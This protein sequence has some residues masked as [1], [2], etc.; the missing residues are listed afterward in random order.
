MNQ[1]DVLRRIEGLQTI[2]TITYKLNIKRQSAIN[3]ISRLKKQGYVT[4][5]GGG[6]KI[7]LYKITMRK[8]RNRDIGMFDILNKYNP[9][10]Q[11]RDWYDHQVHGNYTIED[12]IVDAIQTGSF[13]AILATLRLF[14]H[15]T[16]WSRL[17]RLAKERG[18]WQKVGALYDV[19]KIYYKVRRVPAKYGPLPFKK[20][21][22]IRDYETAEDIYLPIEKK[23]KVTIPFRRGDIIKGAS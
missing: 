8:Q 18:I 9:N 2:K 14:N 11:L 16:D 13:R 19:A 17:Y 23:W 22:L 6:K 1:E 20:T 4:T 15:I 3:L 10:F 7:R 5:R 21:Y 12:A